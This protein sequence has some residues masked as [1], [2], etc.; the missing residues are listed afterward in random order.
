MFSVWEDPGN[1]FVS[2]LAREVVW[3]TK[4]AAGSCE[5]FW[6][7]IDELKTQIQSTWRINELTRQ[8]DK[9]ENGPVV[10]LQNLT[11]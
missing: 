9:G 10:R 5:D 8:T 11:R 7:C 2:V 1:K 4:M 6:S 3:V